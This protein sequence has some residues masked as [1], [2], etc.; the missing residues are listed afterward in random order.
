ML[1]GKSN[2]WGG[3]ENV[4][5]L[6][7]CA[8]LACGFLLAF[9]GLLPLRLQFVPLA[10]QG[11]QAIECSVGKTGIYVRSDICA[12]RTQSVVLVVDALV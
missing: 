1:R 8:R 11:I 10:L 7:W 12:N 5:F 3:I 4:G 9:P 6:K 2:Y